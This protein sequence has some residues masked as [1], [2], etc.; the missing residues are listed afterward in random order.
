M[1]ELEEKY[2]EVK[3]KLNTIESTTPEDNIRYLINQIEVDNITVSEKE[4][5][6]AILEKVKSSIQ[7]LSLKLS[8]KGKKKD[9]SE[10]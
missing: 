3:K 9:V 5:V 8:N 6:L 10:L 2:Q 4:R 7:N 1:K